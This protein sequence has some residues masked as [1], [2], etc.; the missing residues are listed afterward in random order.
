MTKFF[1]LHIVLAL[2]LGA[3]GVRGVQ[4]TVSASGRDAPLVSIAVDFVESSTN[5]ENGK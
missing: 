3:C 1:V 5:G 4:M 2:V